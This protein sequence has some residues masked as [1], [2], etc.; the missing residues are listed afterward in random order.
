M[1]PG[2]GQ[3]A[4]CPSHF[5]YV[6]SVNGC[7][8]LVLDNLEWTIAGLRCLSLHPNAHLLV[9]N[10]AAEQRAIATWLATYSGINSFLGF[11]IGYKLITV[12][13]YLNQRCRILCS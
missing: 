13:L 3:Y 8:S 10:N 11:F 4:V 9:I 7:Y 6:P 12:A 1:T 2:T 5:S